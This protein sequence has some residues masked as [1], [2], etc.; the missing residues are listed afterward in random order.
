MPRKL[1]V[2]QKRAKREAILADTQIE[3]TGNHKDNVVAD[4]R[5]RLGADGSIFLAHEIPGFGHVVRRST[6]I[7][8][9]DYL[10]GG[11]LPMGGAVE[12]GGPYSTGKSTLATK[13]CAHVQRTE[14]DRDILWCALEDYDRSWMRKLGLWVPFSEMLVINPATKEEVPAD[15]FANASDTELFR[16]EELG[17]SD[18]YSLEEGRLARVFIMQSQFGD[19]LLAAVEQAIIGNTFSIIVVDSLAMIEPEEWLDE[20]STRDALDF[21]R[22]VKLIGDYTKRACLRFNIRYDDNGNRTQTGRNQNQTSVVNIQQISTKMATG[23]ASFSPW[24]Q[25]TIKGG[26][27]SKHNHLSINA[28]LQGEPYYY[29]ESGDKR[30]RVGHL[31]KMKNLKS[32]MGMPYRDSDIQFYTADALDIGWRAGDMNVWLDAV[33]LGVMAGTLNKSGA[34]IASGDVQLGQGYDNA[35]QFLRDNPEWYEYVKFTALQE[36]NK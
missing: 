4:L 15:P 2:G 13:A 1:T 23:P 18:P 8:S 12:F 28:F 22:S 5:R 32:K 33:R 27:G 3:R 16:M 10:L 17:I 21:P 24:A 31:I 6:G 11:G 7:P 26:E 34:W 36:L 20:K 30:E 9:L 35:A 14:P 25:F 19:G 29:P